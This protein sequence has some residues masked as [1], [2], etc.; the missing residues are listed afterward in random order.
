MPT[1]RLLDGREVDSNSEEHR[2]EC[3]ARAIAQLRTLADR[4]AHLEGIEAK[5]GKAAADR[6]RETI[7]ALWAARP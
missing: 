4:R 3:E 6:L 5:R 2:H 1:V 7:K